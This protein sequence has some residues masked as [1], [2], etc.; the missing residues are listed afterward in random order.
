MTTSIPYAYGGEFSSDED[1]ENSSQV[2]RNKAGNKFLRDGEPVK[3]TDAQVEEALE[4][5]RK[6]RGQNLELSDELIGAILDHYHTAR[7]PIVGSTRDL[8]KRI[9]IKLVLRDENLAYGDEPKKSNNGNAKN[10]FTAPD[11]YSSDEDNDESG[12]DESEADHELS[13][14]QDG[15]ELMEVDQDDDIEISPNSNPDS[16]HS[17][18][19]QESASDTTDS[20]VEDVTPTKVLV[21]PQH[22]IQPKTMRPLD[23]SSSQTRKLT[24][25]DSS[26]SKKAL[27]RGKIETKASLSKDA[28]LIAADKKVPSKAAK[29]TIF[30]TTAKQPSCRRSRLKVFL[31]FILVLLLAVALAYYFRS[32]IKNNPYMSKIKF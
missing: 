2:N 1:N 32:Q 4:N 3:P 31:T 15:S 25:K 5:I 23:V 14:D 26:A 12:D 10:K 24:Q 9:I 22:K 29:E 20:E 19:N 17:G 21:Q 6:T 13:Y 16:K 27:T 28:K 7:G 11:A 18:P 30:E 8:Y